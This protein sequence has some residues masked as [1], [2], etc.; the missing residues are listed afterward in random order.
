[1]IKQCYFTDISPIL[2]N[3]IL[4]EN[5]KTDFA[6]TIVDLLFMKEF[7]KCLETK[8]T[9]WKAKA[10]KHVEKQKQKYKQLQ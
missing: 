3:Q 4:L 7:K 6:L 10:K 1:M 5:N 9:C 8:K 2:S